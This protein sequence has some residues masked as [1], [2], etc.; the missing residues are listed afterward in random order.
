M[1]T[2]TSPSSPSLAPLFY[3][4]RRLLYPYLVI[5]ILVV[6]LLLFG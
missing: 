1:K 4:N 5:A 3:M 2:E 6:V